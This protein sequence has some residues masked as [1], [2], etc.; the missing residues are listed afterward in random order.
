MKSPPKD[1][2]ESTSVD[3]PTKP[4]EQ[5]PKDPEQVTKKAQA[6][7]PETFEK[8]SDKSNK[9]KAAT[10]CLAN[11]DDFFPRR[12]E[13]IFLSSSSSLASPTTTSG[14]FEIP[15]VNKKKAKAPTGKIIKKKVR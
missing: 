4:T 2:G 1:D 14:G 3:T 5:R 10:S 15:T 9:T 12:S 6:E 13:R 7:Y 11:N 8:S